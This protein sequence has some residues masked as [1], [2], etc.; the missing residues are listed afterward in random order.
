MTEM[1]VGLGFD[2][3][4]TAGGRQLVLGGVKV[5]V[6]FGLEG[7][8]D[9]DVLAHAV[10]DALLGATGLGHIGHWFPDSDPAYRG[11]DSLELLSRVAAE[12]RRQGWSVVNIDCVVVAERPR[13]APFVDQMAE[14]LS[15]AVGVP[16]SSITI[17]PKTADAL[18]GALGEGRGM[19]AM[20]VALLSRRAETPGGQ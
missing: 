18:G 3:H 12:M 6:D 5:P 20:A 13:L 15:G 14:R 17:K 7:H 11:A 2:S 4:R 1:R 9:A 10:I 16:S 19:S 8:S